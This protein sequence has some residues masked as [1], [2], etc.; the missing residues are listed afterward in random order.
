MRSPLYDLKIESSWESDQHA[1]NLRC[2]FFMLQ[3]NP[4]RL[5]RRPVMLERLPQCRRE[6]LDRERSKT[7]RERGNR[8]D[9]RIELTRARQRGDNCPRHEFYRGIV[10]RVD[11]DGMQDL[12]DRQRSRTG[13]HDRAWL[14]D[15]LARVA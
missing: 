12:L 13:A 2:I 10:R 7:G 14:N 9:S 6:L 4:Q 15:A 11:R 8:D 5:Q 1:T 3:Y